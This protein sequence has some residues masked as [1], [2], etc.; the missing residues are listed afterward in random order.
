MQS[1]Q[2]EGK[3]EENFLFKKIPININM[4]EFY[5]KN[6][7]QS[8][9]D[10]LNGYIVILFDITVCGN[11]LYEEL[12]VLNYFKP[13]M[14]DKNL[15]F[16]AVAGLVDSGE[17]AAI[18]SLNRSGLLTFPCKVVNV[19]ELYDRFKLD[20]EDFLDTP[21]FLY[22]SHEYRVLDVFKPQYMDTKELSKWLE[23]IAG[24]DMF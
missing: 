12:R 14:G 2:F 7:D 11:C 3:L 5:F 8:K 9:D 23:I 6:D 21:F 22:I 10:V 16:L 24:Q 15:K 4:D 20:K 1:R 18:I 13:M 19:K 17:E